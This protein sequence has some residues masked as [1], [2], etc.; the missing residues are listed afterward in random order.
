MH[1]VN[2]WPS[3]CGSSHYLLCVTVISMSYLRVI[4]V[5]HPDTFPY[6]GL[7]LRCYSRP[8]SCVQAVVVVSLLDHIM[9][10]GVHLLDVVHGP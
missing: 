8:F 3:C 9:V 5:A 6:N 2:P 10:L 7:L 1:G 4:V